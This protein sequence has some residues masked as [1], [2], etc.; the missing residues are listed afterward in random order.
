MVI[1][2]PAGPSL[3]QPLYRSTSLFIPPPASPSL[4]QPG[5]CCTSLVIAPPA[6]PSLHQ[7]GHRYTSLVIASPA[8]SSLHQHLHRSTSLS[9]TPPA[10][11][12]LHQ[13]LHRSTSLSIT[14]PAWSLL[15]QHLRRSTS[16][17]IAPPASPTEMVNWRMHER[18]HEADPDSSIDLEGF[19]LV[20]MDRNQNSGKKRGGADTQAA[21][22]LLHELVSQAETEAPDAANFIMGDFN[23]CSLKEH[24]PTYQQYVTCSTRDKACLDLCYGNIQDAFYSKA[25]PGLGNSDH[26]M[27]KLTPAYVPRLRREKVKKLE[28]KCWTATATDALQD[29]F[30]STDWDVVTDGTDNVN[31]AAFAI[32][33]YIQFC[34][35]LTIRKKTIKMFPNNKP[36]VTPELKHL[37]NQK[38]CLFKSANHLPACYLT[39]YLLDYLS[40]CSITWIIKSKGFEFEPQCPVYL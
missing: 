8:W 37:L 22:T 35:D 5:H 6:S 23:H 38:K 39:I 2:P 18:R 21:A 13:H 11:S 27:I 15:H 20:R 9:I 24:L 29:C 25:L 4:H 31:D 34:E 1:S 36:W 32:T 26:N 19:T 10:G 17:V 40:T 30:A 33:G 16:L 3:H 28:V 12:L 14:P 7:P